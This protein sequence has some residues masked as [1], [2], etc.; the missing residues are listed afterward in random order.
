MST[1][2]VDAD[3][4]QDGVAISSHN[5]TLASPDTLRDCARHLLHDIKT[6]NMRRSPL[7]QHLRRLICR[8]AKMAWVDRLGFDIQIYSPDNEL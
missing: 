5:Y 7:Q 3:D 4:C 8:D 2:S 6:H 1:R